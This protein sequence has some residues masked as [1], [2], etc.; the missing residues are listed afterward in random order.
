MERVLVDTGPLVA[1]LSEADERHAAAVECLK[2]L[3]APLFTC[4]PVITEAAWLLRARPAAVSRMLEMLTSGFLKFLPLD[5]SA[6]PALSNLLTRYKKLNAQLADVCLVHLAEREGIQ[7][8]FTF[9]RR[10]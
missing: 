10:D 9:D 7:T 6:A 5:E 4:S 1:I 3:T 8:V 2:R